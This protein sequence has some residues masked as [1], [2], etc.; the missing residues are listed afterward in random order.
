M[1]QKVK[2]IVIFSA[3]AI[4]AFIALALIADK[5]R[6]Y[7]KINYSSYSVEDHGAKAFYL[8]VKEYGRFLKAYNTERYNKYARFLPDNSLTVVVEPEVA[9]LDQFEINSIREHVKKGNSFIFLT[10]MDP[11]TLFGD[12]IKDMELKM[13][14]GEKVF[15]FSGKGQISFFESFAVLNDPLKQDNDKGAELLVYIGEQCL[16]NNYDLVLI[17]EYYHTGDP[18]IKGYDVYGMGLALLMVQICITL[19]IWAVYKGVRLGKAEVVSQTIKRNETENIY[20]LANLYKKTKS[21]RIA[22]EVHMEG[23]LLDIAKYL[24][25]RSVD[26]TKRSEFYSDIRKDEKLKK[27]GVDKLLRLYDSNENISIGN[28]KSVI[29]KIEMIRKEL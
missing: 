18:N 29:D 13:E 5:T 20:A 4:F 21:P 27:L 14:N 26:D 12:L 19:V 16:K 17:N 1:R 15:S 2:R 25:Y 9:L 10:V 24:G 22:F 8:S 11:D 23:L 6:N 28:I 3:L 7:E